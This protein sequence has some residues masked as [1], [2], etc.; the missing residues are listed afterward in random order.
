MGGAAGHMRHP[1]DLDD[2]K[3]GGDLVN[4]FNKAVESIIN[5]N[6]CVKIDGTNPS[7][8]L[9]DGPNGK[10]FAVDRASMKEIDISG[11][12]V[13]RINER[14]PP[15]HGM[16][17]AITLLLD[18]FNEAL[19]KITSEL[20]TLGL[21]DD[22]TIFFNTEYVEGTTNVTEYDENFIA[23]HGINQFYERVAKAGPNKGA[24][25]PGAER[26]TDADGK[27]IKDPSY[28]I[29]YDDN[30]LE[31]L[32]KKVSPI[33][34]QSGFKIYTCIP[35]YFKKDQK[36]NF[37]QLLNSTFTI[38]FDPDEEPL[39][40]PLIKWL[41][42]AKNRKYETVTL[43]DG[44]VVGAMNKDLYV[45]IYEKTPITSLIPGGPD[46]QKAI[47]GAV[48]WHT[49]RILGHEI[50][51]N[52]DSVMGSIENHEGLVLRDSEVAPYPVKITGEFIVGGMASTITTR[53]IPKEKDVVKDPVS[54]GNKIALI[55]GK[56]KPPHRGHL[57][58]AKHYAKIA[59]V[60]KI[61]ISPL[62]RGN[63]SWEDSKAIWEIYLH[64]APEDLSNVIVM[65]SPQNSPVGASFDYVENKNNNSDLAQPEEQIILGASTKGGDQSRFAGN[66][67]K[68]ARNGVSILNPMKY[69]FD[70]IPPELHAGDFSAAITA[71][72][73][74]SQWVPKSSLGNI[75]QIM[76][77]LGAEKKTLALE[78]LFS[79]VEQVLFEADEAAQFAA[80]MI[81]SDEEETEDKEDK[82]DK[83]E[84]L[85]GLEATQSELGREAK[86]QTSEFEEEAEEGTKELEEIKWL[87]KL[88]SQEDD[89]DAKSKKEKVSIKLSKSRKTR[90]E[91]SKLKKQ[92]ARFDDYDI[93][94]EEVSAASGAGAPHGGPGMG[95]RTKQTLIREE[96]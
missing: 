34:E 37:E 68:Y 9:V 66:V 78:S 90:K 42:K 59:D 14:F 85:A 41:Q 46:V 76:D 60:V 92:L 21:W 39:E 33:A 63:I 24:V 52:M 40:G 54:G 51:K 22:P 62:P 56:F 96:E 74:I 23:I 29:P 35:A 82:E 84:D 83:E 11:I 73:D 20:K 55:P 6:P 31:Q 50:L 13:D 75:P 32:I 3:T 5:K 86:K 28:E 45:K 58:M 7:F 80:K 2:V 81:R 43:A 53:H 27:E 8:K 69:V 30:I 10:E 49:M 65:K 36:P 88:F 67:Q 77:I 71:G 72:E 57:D 16:R 17:A 93:D 25:R 89:K 12:T 79:L 64:D 26:P 4:F 87:E 38:N 18:I 70:P 48:F 1:F 61:M 44:K 15:G 19:P 91:I 47:D 94:I 95:K